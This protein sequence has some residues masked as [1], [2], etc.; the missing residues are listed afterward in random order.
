LLQIIYKTNSLERICTNYSIAKRKYGEIMA[1]LIHQRIDQLKS[2]IS[3]EM[4]VRY[5]IGRCHPL[6][7]N[8]KGEYAMDLVHP[9]RLIFEKS[10]ADIQIVRIIKIEDYH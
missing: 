2:A 3:I 1:K 6:E 5:S 10:K 7:G 8:R 9:Y 4:L